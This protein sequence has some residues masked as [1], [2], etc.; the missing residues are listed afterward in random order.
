MGFW[1]VNSD[2]EV[3]VRERDNE[4]RESNFFVNFFETINVSFSSKFFFKK[5]SINK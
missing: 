4:E 5:I 1:G 3:S 2:R